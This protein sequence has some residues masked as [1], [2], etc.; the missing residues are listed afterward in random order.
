LGRFSGKVALVTGAGSGIGRAVARRLVSEGAS[1][2]GVDIAPERLAETERLTETGRPAGAQFQARQGDLADPDSCVA[3]V[4]AAVDR[5]GRLDLL[6]NVAGIY[7][8]EHTPK[9]T[10]E[11]YRRVMAV[12]LDA[13]FFLAQAAI[14]YLLDSGGNIVNIASNAGIQ[15]VPYSAAYCMS[16]G[17]VIQLTRS[18]AV[19][20]LKTPLRVNAIAPAGTNTNIASSATF[21]AEMDPDLAVRM[22]GLRGMAEPEE[23]AAV[24]AFLA[25]DEATSV[26]GAVYTID[27]G[28]TI[29]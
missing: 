5:F 11:Q 17:G 13:Y 8:A 22:A 10:L 1:V 12:N 3:A 9:M 27:N 18:L 14:P 7:V 15:G 6:G 19:E 20:Y 23:V 24:F 29:S 26:T 4:V 21:P 28:L 25:S 16:K 2:L